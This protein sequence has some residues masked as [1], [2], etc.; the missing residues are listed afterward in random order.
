MLY[1]AVQGVIAHVGQS[2]WVLGRSVRENITLSDGSDSAAEPRDPTR[3][4]RV[5][6]ACGLVKDLADL[7]DGDM[8]VIVDQGSTLSGKLRDLWLGLAT[9]VSRY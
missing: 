5:V 2:P 6:E 7:S 4:R 1:C 8:T 9:H 3:Y